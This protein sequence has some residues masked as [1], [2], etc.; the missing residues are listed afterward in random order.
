MKAA[1]NQEN[2]KERCENNKSSTAW[3]MHFKHSVKM[4]FCNIN[5]NINVLN[6]SIKTSL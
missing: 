6:K 1:K 3:K 2:K 4:H 5:I